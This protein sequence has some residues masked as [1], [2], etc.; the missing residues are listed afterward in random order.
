MKSY[1]TMRQSRAIRINR[2]GGAPY[3]PSFPNHWY[4]RYSRHKRPVRRADTV[5]SRD[6]DFADPLNL[7]ARDSA[8]ASA[9]GELSDA[10]AAAATIRYGED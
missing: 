6:A 9:A 4:A 8:N 5:G 1:N 2:K 10:T 3:R 7:A